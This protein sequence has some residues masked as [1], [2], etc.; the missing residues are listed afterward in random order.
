MS[1][2][3][4]FLKEAATGAVILGA[5]SKLGIAALAGQERRQG[6]VQG[7]DCAGSGTAWSGWKAR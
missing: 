5:Q 2:R 4:D 7:C 3:R 1:S 6:Q